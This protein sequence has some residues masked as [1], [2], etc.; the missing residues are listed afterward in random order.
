MP[1]FSALIPEAYLSISTGYVETLIQS[2]REELSTGLMRLSYPSGE[3]L[4]FSFLEGIQQKLYRCLEHKV[5]IV[6]RQAWLD[7]LNRSNVSVGFMSLPA[8]AMRFVRI[9]HETPVVRVEQSTYQ[10]E[11]LAIQSEKWAADQEPGI[12]YIQASGIKKY[13]LIAGHSTPI[14]EELSFVEDRAHFNI[15]DASFPQRLPKLD[16]QVTRYVSNR[17]HDL[18]REYEL[19]LAFS[20]LM[21]MLFNRFSELAGRVL[22]ERLCEQ[23]SIWTRESG[24]N[25]VVTSNGVVNHHYFDSLDSAIGVYAEFLQHFRNE[26]SHAIGAR[27]VDNLARETLIKLDPYRRNLLTQHIYSQDGAGSVTGVVWR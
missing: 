20:P 17:D 14:I 15:G 12:V 26:A 16:Y 18:W 24:W 10:P 11:E 27:L 9:V 8:D 4:L 5:E 13:Y 22:T 19:R 6:P 7:A 23:L 21:R 1:D 25:I 2:Q 3:N